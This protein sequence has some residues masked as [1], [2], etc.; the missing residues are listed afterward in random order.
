M[1]IWYTQ[2][3]SPSLSTQ[4]RLRIRSDE[5]KIWRAWR[6]LLVVSSASWD[7]GYR[8][9]SSTGRES[10]TRCSGPRTSNRARSVRELLKAC[11]LSS[12]AQ[13]LVLFVCSLNYLWHFPAARCTERRRS[14]SA[15][16]PFGSCCPP[17]PKSWSDLW[18]TQS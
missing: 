17:D 18:R 16:S 9:A 12:P 6:A 3:S 1:P 2:R 11:S 8:S 7:S 10:D 15:R 4:R 13:F 14:S 5:P